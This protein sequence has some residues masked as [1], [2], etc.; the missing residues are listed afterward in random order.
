MAKARWA[1]APDTPT[2]DEGGVPGLYASFWHGLW[3][4]KATPPNIIAKL[5][6]AVVE[7]LADPAVHQR[8]LIS[9]KSPGPAID[10]RR[11]GSQLNRKLRS[12][13]GGRSSRLPG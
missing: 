1:E 12:K 5:D 10:K 7:S 2:S 6:N 11:R 4:P 3:A 9:D 8:T 13:N